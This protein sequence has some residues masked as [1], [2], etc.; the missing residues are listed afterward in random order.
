MTFLHIIE[1]SKQSSLRAQEAK[2]SFPPQTMKNVPLKGVIFCASV[3]I[4]ASALGT[5]LQEAPIENKKKC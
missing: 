4:T 5:K 3:L 1:H 2:C